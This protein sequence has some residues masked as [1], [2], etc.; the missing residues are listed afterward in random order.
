MEYIMQKNPF[1]LSRTPKI[2]PHDNILKQRNMYPVSPGL[3]VY[4]A[5]SVPGLSGF[6]SISV[7]I[8]FSRGRQS[9]HR[10]CWGSWWYYICNISVC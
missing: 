9:W 2:M 5:L 4:I 1:L 8:Y 6:N 3:Y 7:T 10:C